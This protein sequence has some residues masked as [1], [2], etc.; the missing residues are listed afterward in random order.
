MKTTV[1]LMK[2]QNSES[3]AF[4][5]ELASVDLIPN[6]HER[7]LLQ[8]SRQLARD[9]DEGVSAQKSEFDQYIEDSILC[10]PSIRQKYIDLL[11]DAK[12]YQEGKQSNL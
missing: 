8:F 11:L 12:W 4:Q 1:D 10:L 3:E 7:E 6:E 5:L 9:R 2:D